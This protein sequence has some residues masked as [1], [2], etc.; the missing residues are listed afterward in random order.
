[1]FDY[2]TVCTIFFLTCASIRLF[3]LSLLYIPFYSKEYIIIPHEN[4]LIALKVHGKTKQVLSLL[5]SD[6]RN[7]SPRPLW[8]WSPRYIS[9]DVIPVLCMTIIKKTIIQIAFMFIQQHWLLQEKRINDGS[10]SLDARRIFQ[11]WEIYFQIW[12]LVKWQP[13]QRQTDHFC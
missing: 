5:L 2:V 1:M 8:C 9:V 12:C 10:R 4:N 7:I 11:E 13:L 3:F 6:Y